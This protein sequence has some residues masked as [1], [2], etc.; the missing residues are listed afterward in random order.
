MNVW[1]VSIEMNCIFY[2][3]WYMKVQYV[4]INLW[5][6]SENKQVNK[7]MYDLLLRCP[8]IFMNQIISKARYKQYRSRNLSDKALWISYRYPSKRFMFQKSEVLSKLNGF[9]MIKQQASF[10]LL[11][12]FFP[13]CDSSHPV[14]RRTVIQNEWTIVSTWYPEI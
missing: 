6:M 14:I 8:V 9:Q 11:G 13:L 5:F 3:R 7:C 10:S 1:N 4:V 12:S 2:V